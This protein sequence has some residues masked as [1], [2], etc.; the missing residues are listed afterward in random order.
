MGVGVQIREWS[1]DQIKVKIPPDVVLAV[2]TLLRPVALTA[3]VFAV[4]RVTADM[5]WTKDFPIPSGLFSHWQVWLVLGVLLQMA[6]TTLGRSL[7]GARKH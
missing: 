5:S 4:W 7:R 2:S 1:N 6:S 3:I